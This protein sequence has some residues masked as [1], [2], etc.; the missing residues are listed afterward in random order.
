MLSFA[1]KIKDL[2]PDATLSSSTKL[3]LVNVVSF[4]GQ[5]DRAFKKEHTKEEAF[6]LDKVRCFTEVTC[7]RDANPDAF[8]S[9]RGGS[10]CGFGGRGLARRPCPDAGARAC[11]RA[12]ASL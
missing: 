11:R 2:F 3:V 10:T 7:S 8:P 6:W 5:W 9:G 1:E 12:R 4:K